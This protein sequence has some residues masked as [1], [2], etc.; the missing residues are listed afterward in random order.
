MFKNL[1]VV[2]QKIGKSLMLPVSVLPIAGILLGVGS[3]GLS[4]IPVSVS[5]V[6]A[7]AGGSVFSNMPLI[8]AIGVALGFTNNDGVS[9]LAS[10][11]AY[12]IMSKTML[13]VAP[14]V[15]GL[16]PDS[17]EIQRL[18]DTGV[19][20]GIIAGI[21]AASMFNRFYRIKLPEYLGF[22]AGKRFVP[23]I[24][25]LIA[26]FVGILLSFIWP[27]IGTAIQRFSEW[28]A[29]QNPAVAFGIYGV[30]E[31]ALVPFGLHHIWNVPFQMQVG[32]YV[33]SAGQVFHGDIPRYMAGDPTAGMLSGGFLFKMFGL[34]AAAIAIWHT[35]RPENR[36]KVGGIMISAALTAFLTG[37]TEPIEFSF[38]FV[39]PILYVI[40]AILA[41]LAFVICI[42]LGMRDGTSFSH[43]LIDFIVLSG[44]SSKLYLFPIIGILYAITYY[45]IFR[46]LIVKLN[47]KT[48]GRE[49]EEKNAKQ[50]DKSA[51]GQSLV[52]AFGGKDNISSLDACIT[53]LRIGVKEIDKVDRDELKRLGAAGVVVVGS[54]IQAIFGPKSDN[55]KTEMDEYI[56]SLDL[57]K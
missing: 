43:G 3:A 30:V 7:E 49:V 37:I 11:V 40:H 20:G 33:N 56:R 53:R 28:A 10:V 41:G 21:I 13:V 9:A 35:A 26:I 23:I 8:F 47:L 27:P 5:Q 57:T 46:F 1:F 2:L 12:G 17:V 19:L 34:P 22:F 29:Y 31:R 54:G 24:S 15:L 55:L 45:S 25:G 36:V 18:T 6:M 48:P 52:A 14:W 50:A 38:M 4:W 39:A 51:M 42:L 32:E 44:N 16:S